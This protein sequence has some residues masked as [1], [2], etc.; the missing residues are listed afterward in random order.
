MAIILV[1]VLIYIRFAGSEA[2]MGEEARWRRAGDER[3]AMR[4]SGCAST[5][6]TIVGVLVVALPAGPDRR[7][8]RL[9]LQQPIGRYNFTWS[10]FTLS[11]WGNAFGIEELTEALLTSI[12][13]A[14]AGDADLDHPR[15]D[16]GAGPGPP[17]VLRPSPGQ[18][19]DRDPDGDPRGRDGRRA[20]LLL[21]PPRDLLARVRDP[22]DRPR[23][24]LHQLRGGRRALAADRLRPP[25][26]EAARD[27]GPDRSPPSG[28]SPC[29]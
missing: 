15:D 3:P 24:V 5:R 6:S 23:D 10:G 13:L 1:I 17:P 25:L 16:D 27:L 14:R 4:G 2:L 22:A 12:K 18:L 29:R 26:E 20:A 7:H 19:P 11:H 28:W 21:P 8:L 9:L